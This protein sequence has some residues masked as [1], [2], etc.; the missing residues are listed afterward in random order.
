MNFNWETFAAA[1]ESP[2]G[3]TFYA[4]IVLLLLSAASL[5]LQRRAQPGRLSRPIALALGIL[6]GLRLL[7]VAVFAMAWGGNADA[8]HAMAPFERS[9]HLLGL[10]SAAWLWTRPTGE[11]N[12]QD[13]MFGLVLLGALVLGIALHVSWLSDNL[14]TFNYTN[15]DYLW[16]IACGLVLLFA[17]YQLVRARQTLGL[18]FLTLLMVGQVLHL[19]LA[20]PFGNM[21]LATQAATLIGLPLLFLLPVN[22]TA[23]IAKQEA[24]DETEPETEAEA[25]ELPDG[26]DYE[27]LSAAF[28]ERET[29]QSADQLGRRLAN[30][31]GA[32]I[33]AFA[34]SDG[35]DLNIIAGYNILRETPVEPGTLPLADLPEISAALRTGEPVRL[36]ADERLMELGTLSLAFR[37][38]FQASLLVMPIASTNTAILLLSL[39]KNWQFEDETRL[40][41]R[42]D[43][44]RGTLDALS[45]VE[46][47]EQLE[48]TDDNTP[49]WDEPMLAQSPSLDL[50]EQL[51]QLEA[52]NER[53]RED[54]ERL[55]VHID[56]LKSAAPTAESQPAM[57]SNELVQALQLENER[58][59]SALASA[60][61]TAP[62]SNGTGIDT[63]Q[64]KE[65]LRL[66]MEE[67]ARLQDDLAA[68]QRDVLAA[69]VGSVSE[70]VGGGGLGAGQM[71]V[72]ASIAQEL[73]QPLSSIVG[74]TDLLLGESVGI[75]GALQRKFLERVRNS[76]LR[77]NTLID[78]LIRIAE[79]DE[80]GYSATRKPVD[81][82]GVIDDAI[83]QLRTQ[84]QEKRIAMRVDLPEQLPELNT[85]RDALQQ[86]LYHLL[87]NADA[88]T[89]AEGIITLRAFIDSQ[90]DLGDFVL[91]QVSDSGGGI[92]DDDLP[93]VFSRVYRASNPVIP[94]VGDTGVG[95][96]IA[97][98][99][100]QAL[101]GRIWVESE[102]GVGATFSVLLP[103]NQ[104]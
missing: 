104:A 75:L 91:I 28:Q 93:R 12:R 94:G 103:L 9:L 66:A 39:E 38:S 61:E 48:P 64:A 51:E 96:T 83:G 31:F 34:K 49:L 99:L 47:S 41:A 46:P 52:E 59:K 32:D 43:E 30:E 35:S 65:E 102:A 8:A 82:S 24:I 10:I 50:Q 45:G 92:P 5:W 21:P 54:I 36:S 20:E 77:M 56:E 95:L 17:F 40:Q 67:V 7:E 3:S 89:P 97:E 44:I 63:N 55:L 84:L 80:A 53:Y 37:L 14:A 88:A 85:D 2:Q 100:T 42:S 15:L 87:Q 72:I 33:C 23:A 73:R 16:S 81:L 27:S 78:N 58:L 98:T 74:Y 57:Q 6:M 79:L 25:T 29:P 60:Q 19:F 76:T 4:L 71:E 69:G 101:G 90:Q 62:A 1:L 22:A 86:I 70:A 11:E 26:F 18:V 13:S 68:A